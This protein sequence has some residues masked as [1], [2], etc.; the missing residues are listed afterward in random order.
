MENLKHIVIRNA[1]IIDKESPYHKKKKDILIEDGFI[2]KIDK[3]ISIKS[4]FFETNFFNLILLF[5][6]RV[7][8]IFL[9]FDLLLL[10]FPA[11]AK[12]ERVK[13]IVSIIIIYRFIIYSPVLNYIILLI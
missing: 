10:T 9:A 12:L 1:T 8:L 11:I 13:I 7:Y 5:L 3:N 2:K 6:A 4:A